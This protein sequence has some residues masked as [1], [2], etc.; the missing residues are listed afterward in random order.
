MGFQLQK[1]EMDELCNCQ[2]QAVE[3]LLKT[4]QMKMAKYGARKAA[5]ADAG[6]ADSEVSPPT[7]E[8]VSMA[9]SRASAHRSGAPGRTGQSGVEARL[10]QMGAQ[11]GGGMRELLAEKDLNIRELRETV[12]ILE[13]KIQK[14]EQL[15]RLKDSKIATL[16]AK[17]QQ[18]QQQM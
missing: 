3:R 12:D 8:P 4:L 6:A 18:Q 16:H 1:E 17:L 9:T 10:E 15:V 13:I 11:D 5:A 2:T 14:L 7:G